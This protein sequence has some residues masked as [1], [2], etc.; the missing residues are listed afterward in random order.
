VCDQCVH[1]NEKTILLELKDPLVKSGAK[2]EAGI[3]ALTK[4]FGYDTFTQQ[5]E[6]SPYRA[7]RDLEQISKDRVEESLLGLY[8]LITTKWMSLEKAVSPKGTFVLD[9]RIFLNPK[10]GKPLT[11]AEWKIIKK[12]I[13]K[14]FD[15]IYATEE[16]R[17]ALHA[18]SLGKVLKGLPLNST[19]NH[20][21]ATLKQKVD[22]AMATMHGPVWKNAVTFAQ[23]H[24][25]ENIVAL[26]ANQFKKIHDTIQQSIIGRDNSKVLKSKLFDNFGD[27]N[28][29]WRR[30]AETEI[31]NSQNNG[32][33][34]AELDRAGTSRVFM[35]GISS[36]GACPWCRKE[37][38]HQIVVL[39]PEPPG[40]G[41]QVQ[42]GDK[43]YTAIWPGKS[44]VGRSRR[45]WWVAAGTQHPHCRCTWVKH[46]PGFDKWD[47]AFRD[48]LD[49]ATVQSTARRK[50]KSFNEA[51]S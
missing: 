26:K 17:I 30:I 4:A 48:A 5:K 32:Q 42:V 19:L 37:V 45:N 43:T 12:D 18:L 10:T 25:A 2:Y 36:S 41:D 44:N 39:L 46:T 24:A 35:E 38:D 21:Y 50:P 31:N 27:M 28:R 16:N 23:Q 15:Y 14:A 51:V 49:S 13:L 3:D 40:G 9:N 20:G 7:V 29:D 8:N 33:L 22:D 1:E 6:I 34:L 11:N 47:K